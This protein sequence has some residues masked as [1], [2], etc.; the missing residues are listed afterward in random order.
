M[1]G[2]KTIFV[3]RECGHTEGKWMGKCPGCGAWHS[4]V[5]ETVSKP[6]SRHRKGLAGAGSPPVSL[7]DAPSISV[8][9]GRVRS[10]MA[11]MDRVL[12]GGIVPGGVVLLGG[13]PGIGKSTLLLQIL[14][15]LASSG[16]KVLYV[17]GEESIAQIRMRAE[18]LGDIPGRLLVASEIDIDLI[19]AYVK[20]SAPEILAV[21]S[22]QTLIHRDLPASPGSV[23]QV[24]ETAERLVRLAKPM[25][26]P[27]F[28]V[29]HVTKDG[30]LAGPR[31]L[32]HIVDTV[33]FFEGERAQGFR[34]VRAVKNRFGP[35]H[36]IGI[37]EMTGSGLR[38]IVNPSE[39]FI[40]LG[41]RDVPGS[42]LCPCMEG[43]RPLILEIQALV[44]PSHL[45]MPRRTTTGLDS[46]RIAMLAAVAERHLGIFLSDR[47]IFVNVVGGVKVSEP[48][49]DLA[50]LL[51]MVSSLRGIAV[52]AGAAAFGEVGLTGEIRGVTRSD[53]RL[54]ELARIGIAHAVIPLAGSEKIS[55]PEGVR[56]SRVGRLGDAVEAAIEANMS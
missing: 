7:T 21:D 4:F 51:A 56:I 31:V 36:E 54:A 40:H 32:E 13:E 52:G 10:G 6:G 43:T 8:G 50:I 26:M 5:E 49:A 46:S 1:P 11:E 23:T 3:C 19:E 22:V 34:I 20:E 29:G 35:T 39:V 14:L 12:G 53:R 41:S 55:F 2:A 9:E 25:G 15:L 27:V 33:L 42:V 44:S 47:D 28:L 18:R 30:S 37:F 16:K 17:S 24:R 45:A 48:A 38:E